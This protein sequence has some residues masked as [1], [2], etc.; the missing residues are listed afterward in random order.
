V[1]LREP[2][3]DGTNINLKSYWRC[4]Y[5]IPISSQLGEARAKEVDAEQ[6]CT[7]QP[8]HG[9]RQKG[10]VKLVIRDTSCK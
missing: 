1:E 7:S 6:C 3:V 8:T 10:H 4:C 5:K 9:S 2:H